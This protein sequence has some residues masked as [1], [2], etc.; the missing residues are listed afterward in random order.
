MTVPKNQ[1]PITL[2]IDDITQTRVTQTRLSM[3]WPSDPETTRSLTQLTHSRVP[4]H[5]RLRRWW[6]RW[7]VKRIK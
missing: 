5:R 2:T 4:W 3:R 1:H 7:R 6:T